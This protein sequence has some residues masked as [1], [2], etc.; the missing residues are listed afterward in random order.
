MDAVSAPEFLRSAPEL[1]RSRCTLT[2][3]GFDA[4]DASNGCGITPLADGGGADGVEEPPLPHP[5]PAPPVLPTLVAPRAAVLTPNV[6]GAANPGAATAG[7]IVDI[8]E[9]SG[10]VPAAFPAD[11]VAAVAIVAC[12]LPP[13]GLRTL[14]VTDSG[15][16]VQRRGSLQDSAGLNSPNAG[17]GET[18]RPARSA[19]AAMNCTE[20]R[21]GAPFAPG[22]V[23]PDVVAQLCTRAGWP[24]ARCSWP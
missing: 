10:D 8:G 20:C 7:A 21:N 13:G 17:C 14:R 6:D 5:L 9:L 15:R 18:L 12:V 22:A 19:P 24:I 16:G 2:M 11:D 3:L 1:R 4:D 23:L